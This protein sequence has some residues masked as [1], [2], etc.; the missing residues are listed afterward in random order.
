M[1]QV[2][3]T[4]EYL[5]SRTCL[6]PMWPDDSRPTQEFCGAKVTTGA[7]YCDQHREVC[8]STAQPEDQEEESCQS[9]T[10]K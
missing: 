4:E 10:T 7:S 8:Y 6:F 5:M 1:A 3:N 2:V 9:T